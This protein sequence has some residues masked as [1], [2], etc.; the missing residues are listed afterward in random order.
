VDVALHSAVGCRDE[1]SESKANINTF[2]KALM[3]AIH[4]KLRGME[5]TVRVTIT[6]LL[7]FNV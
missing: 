5:H 4:L 6:S 7:C 1:R 3:Q 2:E